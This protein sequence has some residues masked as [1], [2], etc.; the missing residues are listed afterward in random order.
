MKK[1]L[2]ILIGVISLFGCH[3]EVQIRSSFPFEVTADFK[4]EAFVNI[5]IQAI[6]DL[7]PEQI[8]TTNVYSVSYRLLEGKG[9]VILENGEVLEE[10]EINELEGL[11]FK[12]MF[13]PQSSGKI[14]VEFTF[15]DQEGETTVKIVDYS[16]SDTNFNVTTT[17]DLSN[18]TVGQ[19]L[20]ITYDIT[21]E[22]KTSIDEYTLVFSSSKNGFL[23]VNNV[24]YKAGDKI[25]IP[26]LNF[27]AF[28]TPSV[29][30]KHQI[31]NSITANSNQLTQTKDV[32]VSVEPTNFEFNITTP[33]E[34]TVGKT[35]DLD[36]TINE[37]VGTSNFDMQ[38]SIAG[39]N[40]EFKNAN[41]IVLQSNTSYDVDPTFRLKLKGVEEGTMDIKF[42]IKNQFGVIKSETISIKVLP[43]NFDY[44]VKLLDNVI[45]LDRAIRFEFSMNAP[46]VLDYDLS[47]TANTR[48]AMRVNFKIVEEGDKLRIG[49][50]SFVAE[51]LP[52]VA[53]NALLNFT[54]TAS[55]GVSKT[56][57]VNFNISQKP[58]ITTI[59][60]FSGNCGPTI[61]PRQKFRINWQK[62]PRETIVSARIKVYGKTNKT[63]NTTFS[64]PIDGNNATIDIGCINPP[65][66]IEVTIIDSRGQ[67]SDKF[68]A[69]YKL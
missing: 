8:V 31:T 14:S 3:K 49:N 48:G 13:V 12:P 26:A 53:G 19:R 25:K 68:D 11:L 10:R 1:I 30:G 20:Q 66:R 61:V 46:D 32:F 22:G 27:I 33:N 59:Q 44:N 39:V 56:K 23:T 36:F 65:D 47:F 34:V 50:K 16:I 64:T 17:G 35:I 54:I 6:F 69:N 24:D 62:D 21:E 9:E 28:Y 15:A 37:L 57:T 55:N 29:E 52:D 43:I 51:Y 40:G 38:Y 18:I 58:K 7:T 45:T 4:K 67:Q 63:I 60:D 5:P 2:L 42:S 41:N